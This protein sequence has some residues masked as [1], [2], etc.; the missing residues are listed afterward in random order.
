MNG[1]GTDGGHPRD[2]HK[3][4]FNLCSL[5]NHLVQSDVHRF[6]D[7]R[8]DCPGVLRAAPCELPIQ[9]ELRARGIMQ[10]IWSSGNIE[11]ERPLLTCTL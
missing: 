2:W 5:M 7:N 6:P 3:Q 8:E 10:R 9:S 1:I 4:A 11:A